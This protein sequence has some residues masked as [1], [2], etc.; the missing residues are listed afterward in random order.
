MSSI[1]DII[2]VYSVCRINTALNDL[3]WQFRV[4]SYPT[5]IF[6]PAGDKSNSAVF[7]HHLSPTLSNLAKFVDSSASSA[8]E[9]RTCRPACVRSNI[10]TA[11]SSARRLTRRIQHVQSAIALLR[12]HICAQLNTSSPTDALH[13]TVQESVPSVNEPPSSSLGQRQPSMNA[14]SEPV[15]AAP[16]SSVSINAAADGE[17][18]SLLSDTVV[19]IP[20]AVVAGYSAL[21]SD[22]QQQTNGCSVSRILL[23]RDEL[24]VLRRRVYFYHQQLAV[25]RRVYRTLLPL[26]MRPGQHL[27]RRHWLQFQRHRRNLTIRLHNYK[28]FISGDEVGCGDGV[29]MTGR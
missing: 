14:V 20:P 15:A 11:R 7:P 26:S 12:N 28:D 27:A 10:V 17:T 23:V 5:L 6:F 13:P 16:D 3:P 22:E 2:G 29:A 9:M 25:V 24:A 19:H 21:S 18:P 1:T 8:F 4:D